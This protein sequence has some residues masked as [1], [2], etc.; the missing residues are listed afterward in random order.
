MTSDWIE[1]EQAKY[2]V[3]KMADWNDLLRQLGAAWENGG[4]S[5]PDRI[6]DAVVIRLKDSYASSALHAY[7]NAILTVLD[8]MGESMDPDVYQQQLDICDYFHQKAVESGEMKG[9]RLPD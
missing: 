3:L 8:I 9:K 2:A 5:I 4:F 6:E 7:A 1:E